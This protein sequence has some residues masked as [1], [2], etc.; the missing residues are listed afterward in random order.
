MELVC[1]MM[2]HSTL[3]SAVTVDKAEFYLTLVIKYAKQHHPLFHD[4]TNELT[5]CKYFILLYLKCVL[6]LLWYLRL[7]FKKCS[8]QNAYSKQ[9]S[10]M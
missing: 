6:S 4:N 2:L 8:I 1:K 3:Q 5:L 10:K 9:N 7:T